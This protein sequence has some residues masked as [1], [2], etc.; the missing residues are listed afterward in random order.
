MHLNEG[1][2]QAYF[3]GELSSADQDRVAAHIEA[4]QAC[5]AVASDLQSER[6]LAGQSISILEP[7]VSAPDA[8]RM[9]ARLDSRIKQLQKENQTMF[10]KIFTRPAWAAAAVVVVLGM[11]FVFP[12][13]RAL[14]TSFLGLFRVQQI[15]VV[16][17]NPIDLPQQMNSASSSIQQLIAQDAKYEQIGE[18]QQVNSASEASAA[19]GFTARLPQSADSVPSITVE[20]GV[21]GVVNVDLPKVREILKEMNLT[22]IQLPDQLDKAVI[23]INVPKSVVASYGDCQVD[24]NSIVYSQGATPDAKTVMNKIQ[25][26]ELSPNC[27]VLVQVPSPTINA[28]DDLDINQ[29]GQAYLQATGMSVEDAAKLSSKIDWANTL[30]IPIPNNVSSTTDV[31]VDGVSATLIEQSPDYS[32]PRYMLMWVKDGIIYNLSGVGDT[33][34]GVKMA[35]SLQ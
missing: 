11:T 30:V 32:N 14:A 21:K 26:T 12:P 6:S 5:R 23:N 7:S 3:D 25:Q 16:P 27:T 15:A 34:A 8:V 28:P 20:P 18:K 10:K 13:V 29:L 35:N 17:I 1:E 22:D 31:Q 19:A 9:R 4:C 2:I 24:A 33:S